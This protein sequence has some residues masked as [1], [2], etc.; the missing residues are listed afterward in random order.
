MLL[1][2]YELFWFLFDNLTEVS[3]T[4]NPNPP[5]SASLACGLEKIH[6]LLLPVELL[7]LQPFSLSLCFYR[8]KVKVILKNYSF[9]TSLKN[10]KNKI[11]F[12][13][14]Y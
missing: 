5:F 8:L 12:G 7:I 14:C 10:K 1:S 9:G 6:S 2:M 4:V 11:I 3:T 13:K